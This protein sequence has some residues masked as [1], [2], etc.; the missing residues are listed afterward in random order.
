M[1][2]ITYTQ[3]QIVLETPPPDLLHHENPQV[4]SD[5]LHQPNTSGKYGI[6]QPKTFR[7]NLQTI[8]NIDLI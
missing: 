7:P 5:T 3:P 2:Q 4:D 8:H 6:N 1:N